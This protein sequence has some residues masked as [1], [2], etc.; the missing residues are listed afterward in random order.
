MNQLQAQHPGTNSQYPAIQTEVKI[1][2]TLFRVTSVY[3]G[4]QPLE[5]ILLDWAVNKTLNA[6]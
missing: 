4:R 6:S 5:K 2:K 3:K 1:G